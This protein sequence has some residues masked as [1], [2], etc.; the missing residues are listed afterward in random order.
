MAILI[1]LMLNK[2]E[3]DLIF[4]KNTQSWSP[5]QSGS[6]TRTDFLSFWVFARLTLQRCQFSSV[7][8]NCCE[9]KDRLQ[10]HGELKYHRRTFST[11][12]ESCRTLRAGRRGTTL[13]SISARGYQRHCE[14]SVLGRQRDDFTGDVVSKDAIGWHQSDS[15]LHISLRVRV[16]VFFFSLFIFSFSLC[17][18]LGP[19]P[20]AVHFGGN[21]GSSKILMRSSHAWT[22]PVFWCC[23]IRR[24]I[25]KRGGGGRKKFPRGNLQ[26]HTLIIGVWRK[27]SQ[28]FLLRYEMAPPKE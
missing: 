6:T 24:G 9:V 20:P 16:C 22:E 26:R 4:H 21:S 1:K 25:V 5:R 2:C 27:G 7:S 23:V 18:L 28:W 14:A 3:N 8:A 12:L 11:R 17:C 15:R 10:R 19:C 13:L